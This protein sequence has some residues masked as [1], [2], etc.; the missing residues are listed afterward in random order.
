MKQ[1]R[2]IYIREFG[3]IKST[4]IDLNKSMQ[5]CIGNQESLA[6]L[7]YFY[8]KLG[9]IVSEYVPNRGILG[10]YF[11]DISSYFV[12]S[13]KTLISE[14]NIPSDFEVVYNFGDKSLTILAK[15]GTILLFLSPR[16]A[17]TIN[18]LMQRGECDRHEV[19]KLFGIDMDAIFIP[20]FRSDC[21]VELISSTSKDFKGAFKSISESSSKSN[22]IKQSGITQDSNIRPFISTVCSELDLSWIALLYHTRPCY[23]I[24]EEPEIHLD[25]TRQ[26]LAA[27]LLACLCNVDKCRLFITT[28]SPYVIAT[29]N[30]SIYSGLI[31]K[32]DSQPIIPKFLQLDYRQMTAFQAD[33]PA[34]SLFDDE[35][36]LIETKTIDAASERIN[37][38]FQLL[39]EK[40]LEVSK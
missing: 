16:L 9:N 24:V 31:E 6:G 40:E 39:M 18:K 34:Q 20:S 25:S 21:S 15:R 29:I 5:I 11:K 10:I 38:S 2:E 12:Q 8:F 17:I 23:I 22:L 19:N 7:I 36:H 26:S 37:K 33:A 1:V 4:K 32:D 14:K 30:N 35:T 28:N 3:G 27:E 13:F